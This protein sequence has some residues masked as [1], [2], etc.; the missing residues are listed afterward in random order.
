MKRDYNKKYKKYMHYFPNCISK[1]RHINNARILKLKLLI[2][3][4]IRRR[5][6]WKMKNSTE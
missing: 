4:K 5:I 3:K 2:I 1:E 6:V